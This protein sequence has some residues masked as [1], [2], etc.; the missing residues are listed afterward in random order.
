MH[1]PLSTSH[2]TSSIV[3]AGLLV[4]TN[5]EISTPDT[6]RTSPASLLYNADLT[7]SQSL[8]GNLNNCGNKA[9]HAQP[10][11]SQPIGETDGR[12]EG[13]DTCEALEKSDCK[14]DCEHDSPKTEDEPS[15]EDTPIASATDEEDVCPTCLEEYD[16]ENPRILTKC[17]HHFH[18]SCILEWME[19]SDTC[20]ICD[21]IMKIET[22]V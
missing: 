15:K 2:G 9:G 21:Q 11:D 22:Y 19:R 14:T 3:S 7:S 1:E 12:L 20:P 13:S 16:A 4:D 18:L 5:L 6:Y 17:E 10:T 8:P